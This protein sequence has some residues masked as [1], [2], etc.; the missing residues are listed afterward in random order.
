LDNL[1]VILFI[2]I[3]LGQAFFLIRKM[4]F[5]SWLAPLAVVLGDTLVLYIFALLGGLKIGF[6]FVIA[7][8]VILSILSFIP[9]NKLPLNKWLSLP[10]FA[11]F[12]FCLYAWISTRGSLFYFTDDFTHWGV[13]FRYLISVGKL[14]VIDPSLP[15]AVIYD[16]PPFTALFQYFTA[17][18]TGNRESNVL[19][20]QMV[21]GLSSVIAILPI[22]EWRHWKSYMLGLGAIFVSF[23]A[24]DFTFQS[25]QVDLLLGILFAA[26]L[27][28]VTFDAQQ[29][30]DQ[31]IATII[32]CSALILTK[33]T[34]IIYASM[35]ISAEILVFSLNN[36]PEKTSKPY[37]LGS[38][39]QKIPP[40]FLFII[41]VPLL[42]GLTWM[43]HT[44]GFSNN[45]TSLSIFNHQPVSAEISPISIDD[46]EKQL[47]EEERTQRINTRLLFVPTER[48]ISVE[49]VLKSFS[50]LAPF[51]SRL[52]FNRFIE[53]LD[54]GKF[55]SSGLSA[56]SIL[57]ILVMF[58]L[59]IRY[60]I[61]D[62]RMG[63]V[64]AYLYLNLLLF[65]GFLFYC[66]FLITAYNFSFPALRATIVPSLS[67]YIGSYF[68]G[69]WGFI[70]SVISLIS[71]GPCEKYIVRRFNILLGGVILAGIVFF[72]MSIVFK[73]PRP[74]SDTRMAANTIFKS[75]A[76]I[77]FGANDRIYDVFQ[78]EPADRG[79]G[80]WIIRYLLT[81]T[82]TNY[83]GWEL[84]EIIQS[85]D[86]YTVPFTPEEWIT[87]LHDQKYTYVLISHANENFWKRYQALFDEYDSGG[88]GQLY[89]VKSNYLEKVDLNNE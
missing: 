28:Q 54:N 17:Q 13:I 75:L 84:G 72:P 74:P 51:R 69:W 61:K 71:I 8:S 86:F 67:R 83:H 48:S 70:I 26:G 62:T 77:N 15:R 82:P 31:F 32:I 42:F 68:L 66:L 18:I 19:F 49:A 57:I 23:L 45:K 4:R 88:W 63:I 60:S 46:F 34:G 37:N 53:E 64:R 56:V 65:I 79:Y 44:K 58:V 39:F 78:V 24:L 14:P 80:H 16:Y 27:A 40:H 33:P 6:F 59:I 89:K 25:L 7:A 11:F 85:N 76:P 38:I 30:Q 10:I 20:A 5:S 22:S 50:N 87:L 12:F 81:P 35:I 21:L 55:V 47:L 73:Q 3:L 29:P 41:I 9:I 1:R 36:K 2:F 52:I 43:L